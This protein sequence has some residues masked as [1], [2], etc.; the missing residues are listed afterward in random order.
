MGEGSFSGLISIEESDPIP[1]KHAPIESDDSD[2]RIYV[3]K[4]Y[5][6]KVPNATIQNLKSALNHF[7]K[8]TEE[9][10]R[11][12]V[13]TANIDKFNEL[14]TIKSTQSEII[15]S[16]HPIYTNP[17]YARSPILEEELEFIKRHPFMNGNM[18]YVLYKQHFPNSERKERFI[19]D[20]R[21]H[22][23]N[24]ERSHRMHPIVHSQPS[25]R[26][27]SNLIT[28]TIRLLYK[29]GFTPE[30]LPKV[31]PIINELIS[32]NTNQDEIN[33]AIAYLKD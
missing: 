25:P 16:D 18:L 28:Q 11:D 15:A 3:L 4:E 32:Q 31:K 21:A 24:P 20:T 29:A 33:L 6:S 12:L 19:R 5:I 9:E 1:H 23:A 13:K 17:I 8:A 30:T 22:A 10:F 26:V 27:N 14:Y 7:S 2:P